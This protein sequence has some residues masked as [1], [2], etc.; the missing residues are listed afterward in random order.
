MISLDVEAGSLECDL[1]A[2]EIQRRLDN[3]PTTHR[4]YRRG[5][6]AIFLDH[7]L[8]ADQGCDFDVLRFLPD[9]DDDGLPLG[10]LKG[11]VLG[12]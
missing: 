5:Y 1:L 7:V 9:E 6:G 4:R 2:P 12:D 11:W 10:L 3:R 8:Q